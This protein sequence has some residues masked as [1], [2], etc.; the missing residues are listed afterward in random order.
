MSMLHLTH[1][2]LQVTP[3]HGTHHILRGFSLMNNLKTAHRSAMGNELLRMLMTIC[4][5]GGEWCDD[6]NKIPVAAII[7]EWRSQSKKGRYEDAMWSAAGLEQ[8]VGL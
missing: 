3:T 4:S 5:L 2:H 6:F 1:G 7:E 8:A